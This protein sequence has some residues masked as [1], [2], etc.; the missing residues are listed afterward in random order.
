M[1]EGR[2]GVWAALQGAE[3][4]WGWGPSTSVDGAFWRAGDGLL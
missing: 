2:T 4:R 1:W 3:P